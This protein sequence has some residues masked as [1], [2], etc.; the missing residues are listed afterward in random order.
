MNSKIPKRIIQ[1]H[2]SL[3][4][5]LLER[6]AIANVK[7]LHPDFEYLF[8]DDRRVEEFI[9]NEF[10]EYRSVFDAFPVRIQKYDFFRYLAV[11]RLGGFYLDTDMLLA[12]NLSELLTDECVF[13]FEALTINAYLRKRQGMDWEVGNYA[14]GAVPGHPFLRAII[15]NCIR[16]QRDPNWARDMGR[17]VPRWFLDD[18]YVLY[19]TGPL[20]V[21]RTLAE[22]PDSEKRIKILF[23]DDVCNAEHWNR[24]GHFGIH[25]MEGS[26]RKNRGIFHR[27]LMRVWHSLLMR[28][29][30]KKSSKL[31]KLRSLQFRRSP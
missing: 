29:M 18:C 9:D 19:T 10:P 5:P 11:Y 17:A 13:P 14:F 22:F 12:A 23:P 16:A 21:S 31:G 28:K 1:T 25:L 7:L 4:L 26:W 20:L 8:F 30:L 15:E 2:K 6:A 24:F 3:D 27:R